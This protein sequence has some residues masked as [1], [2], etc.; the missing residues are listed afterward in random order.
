MKTFLKT[1][2]LGAVVA[3]VVAACGGGG[4]V[5]QGTVGS[6]SSAAGGQPYSEC[7]RSH[8]VPNFPDQSPGGGIQLPSGVN[9]TS[10]SFEAAQKDCRRFAPG[11]LGSLTRKPTRQQVE[12]VVRMSRCM[13]DHGI[14]GFPDPSQTPVT[15]SS[16]SGYSEVMSRDGVTLAMPKG[17][18]INSPAF[19]AASAKCGLPVPGSQKPQTFG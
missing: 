13:R 8:G 6:A 9:P 19:R 17:M 10:P 7:M 3:V 15:P 1:G 5:N 14:T 16:M 11:P 18:N 12:V 4:S 2:G